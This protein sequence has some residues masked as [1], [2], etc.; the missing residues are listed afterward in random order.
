MLLAAFIHATTLLFIKFNEFIWIR[1]LATVSIKG[2]RGEGGKEA[3]G[4]LSKSGRFADGNFKRLEIEASLQANWQRSESNQARFFECFTRYPPSPSPSF[5]HTL[6]LALAASEATFN[7]Q[8]ATAC[9]HATNSIR[10]ANFG[11]ISWQA[12]AVLFCCSASMCD[13]FY[14]ALSQTR[15][16]QHFRNLIRFEANMEDL[17]EKPPQSYWN[18]NLF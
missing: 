17:P 4:N 13:T 11:S 8:L 12:A 7:F 2:A 5:P 14:R 6:C 1:A 9:C 10:L 15:S 16:T 3:K 18:W